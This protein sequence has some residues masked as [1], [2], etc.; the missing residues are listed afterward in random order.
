[1]TGRL[2]VLK[3]SSYL[4]VARIFARLASLPFFI[5]AARELG[6]A[7]FGIF[8]FVVA[9]VEILNSLSNLGIQRYGARAMVREEFEVRRLAGILLTMRLVFAF[10]LAGCSLALLLYISPESTKMQVVLLGLVAVIMSSMIQTTETLFTGTE[11]FG[12]SAAFQVLGRVIYL[13]IGFMVLGMGLSVVAVM[14]AFVISITV[15]GLLRVIYTVRVVTPFSFRF[16]REE[17]VRVL[18]G[19]M[20][21]ALTAIATLVYY[22]ADTMFLE[23]IKGDVAVGIYGA[24]YSFYSFVIWVPIVLSRTLLPGLTSRYEHDP[25]SGER[26]GWFWYR[27]VGLVSVPVI[28]TGTILAGPVI[29][30]LMPLAYIDSIA[31]LEILL[32]SMPSLMMVSVGFIILTVAD[33]EMKGAHTTIATAVIIVILDL[34]LIPRY[35][36]TGAA[37][38][39]VVSTV[40]WGVQVHWLLHRYVLS[41]EHGV[42]R[43]FGIIIGGFLAMAAATIAALPFG[44]PVMLVAGMAAYMAVFLIGWFIE[45]RVKGLS[46]T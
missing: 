44:L 1:M 24:A 6:P 29:R 33:L 39:M 3:H 11:R 22:R 15:E 26:N 32:W 46:F 12:A 40:I 31:A 19:I 28:F 45:T 43:T 21:F 5:Y 37:A 2:R 36:V 41:A 17:V 38:A 14:W 30:K 13:A 34:V 42:L 4:I 10:V 20:P 8:M 23:F 25:A 35:G 7:L 9:T 16:R 18:R 27:L